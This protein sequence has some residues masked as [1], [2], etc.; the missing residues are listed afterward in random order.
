MSSAKRRRAGA[1]AWMTLRW[2]PDKGPHE[3]RYAQ[4][5]VTPAYELARVFGARDPG[6]PE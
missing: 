1:L 4:L 6:G 3:C 2:R 5:D